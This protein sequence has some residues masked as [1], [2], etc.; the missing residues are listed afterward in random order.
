ATGTTGTATRAERAR[1]AVVPPRRLPRAAPDHRRDPAP[2]LGRD[3]PLRG[4]PALPLRR[5]CARRS[6]R[7]PARYPFPRR[8]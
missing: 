4:A 2:L 7:D 6:R 3:P 8:L 5:V 1:P